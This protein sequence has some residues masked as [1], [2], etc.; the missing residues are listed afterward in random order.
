[1]KA[2]LKIEVLAEGWNEVPLRLGDAAITA[3]T[4]DG[5]P[6]RIVGEA[7]Q[8]YRLLI[9]KKGKEP[10]QMELDLEY[11]RAISRTPGHQQRLVPGPAGAGEPVAGGDSAGRREGESPSADRRH[12]SARRNESPTAATRRSPTKR[13]CWRSSARPRWCASTGRPRPKGPPAWPPWPASRPSSKS[14]SPRAW[15]ASRTTLDYSISRAELAQLA[16]DVP[17]DQKVVNVFDANVRQ[18]SVE[19]VEGGQRITAQLFEPAKASQQVTVELEKFDPATKPKDT[20][21]V[22][23]VK[24]VGVGRQQGVRGGPSGRKPAGRGRQDERPDAGRRRRIARPRSAARNGRSP[25]AMPRSPSSWRLSVEKVQPR[26]TVDSL[27]EA[28]LQPERLTLNL[29]AVYTIEKAGVFS[30]DLGR[31]AGLCRLCRS[32][33]SAARRS[34]ARRPSQVDIAII[35]KAASRRG[36]W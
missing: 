14:G 21:A 20:I 2:K 5:K 28:E 3:A 30:L 17:A 8:D 11:A 16:I 29:T 26:I 23:V 18:W 12:G 34:P 33:R 22:P 35:S 4:L 6:A 15:S 1:M 32:A 19:P 25:T 13:S 31:P 24:A 27:V 36:W 10:E 7:G 9:E